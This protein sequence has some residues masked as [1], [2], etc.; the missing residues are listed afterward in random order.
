MVRISGVVP[1]ISLLAFL[2]GAA[3]AAAA[4]TWVEAKSPNF[5]VVSNGG[6]K[7][8]REVAWQF[9]QIRSA[10][11]KGFPWARVKLN[12]P[13]LVLAA[14]DESSMRALAPTYW[15]NRGNGV[16]SLLVETQDRFYIALRSDVK[17]EDRDVMNPYRMA[18]WSYA[19]TAIEA[20]FNRGLPLWF[21][22]G[23]ASVLSN[24]VVREK[25]IRFGLPIPDLLRVIR[26]DSRLKLTDLFLVD[27]RSKYYTDDFSRSRFDAQSW[28]LVHYL[29][30]AEDAEQRGHVNQLSTLLLAGK[31]SADAIAQVYGSIDA[32]DQ[33]YIR[34]VNKSLLP[35][36]R[37]QVDTNIDKEKYPVRVLSPA[38][39]EA[40]RAGFLTSTGRQAEGHALLE[41]ARH[42]KADLARIAEIDAEALDRDQKIED[43]A[44]GYKRALELGS[45]NFYACYRLARLT[46]N[47]RSDAS[48]LTIAHDLLAK[49]IEL[50]DAYAP[51]HAYLA[52]VMIR[53]GAPAGA[54]NVAQRAVTLEPAES[55]YRLLFAQVLQRMA[56]LDD[57]RTLAQTAVEVA[58]TDQE[59][60]EARALLDELN[61]PRAASPTSVSS[62]PAADT[63]RSPEPPVASAATETSY[64][65]GSAGVVLPRVVR[66]ARP[67][68][69][70]TAMDK[71]VEGVVVLECVVKAD[72]T[73]GD[74]RVVRSL[75]AQFGLDDEAIKAAKQWRFSPGTKDGVPVPV[76]VSIELTF[77]LKK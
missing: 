39:S 20:S 42:E 4:D 75:D 5:T 41:Q 64:R 57:A 27:R 38:D 68:Y 46:L 50:N 15:E 48:A 18:Y 60:Q 77:T 19:L 6:D 12:R 65:A 66:E 16:A 8:A 13:V 23:L 76:L 71:H 1:A 72:G 35:Y 59:R 17:G 62:A 47:T 29:L 10:I 58:K 31:S 40:E 74:V 24:S 37:L 21:A 56:R 53:E 54:F 26:Q 2:S 7:T 36:S 3:R 25:E 9:E 22:E 44:L 33:G 45:R 70:A 32:V 34:H 51:S 61:R 14:R 73:V 11:E 49:S 30:L 52:W 43:A 55:S 28:A 69:T 63:T 67:N